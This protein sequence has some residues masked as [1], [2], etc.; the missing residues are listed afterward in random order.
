MDRLSNW[1]DISDQKSEKFH[2][3]PLRSSFVRS[4]SRATA[5]DRAQERTKAPLSKSKRE[6]ER[7]P[8]ILIPGGASDPFFMPTASFY[9]RNLHQRI[10]FSRSILLTMTILPTILLADD[11]LHAIVG[12]KTIVKDFHLLLVCRWLF[13]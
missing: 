10:S 12:S 4:W 3:V 9:T 5:V 6:R 13:D 7:F 2:F 1:W 8:G 11:A